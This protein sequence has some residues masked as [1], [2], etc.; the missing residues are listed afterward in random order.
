[1][2]AFGRSHNGIDRARLNAFGT[3]NTFLFPYEGNFALA[4]YTVPRIKRLLR[5]IQQSGQAGNGVCATGRAA[6]DG[7]ACAN[8]LGVRA[9]ARV[10]ALA[11]LRLWQQGIDPVNRQSLGLICR[12]V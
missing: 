9:A 7:N 4:F 5:S 10:A 3:A 6:I 2:H 11:T 12:S 1:V 8:R